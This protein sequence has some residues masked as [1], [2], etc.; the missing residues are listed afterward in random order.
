[1]LTH[2]EQGDCNELRTTIVKG[3]IVDTKMGGIQVKFTGKERLT[4]T[5][6]QDKRYEIS[7]SFGLVASRVSGRLRKMS[8]KYH[9]RVIIRHLLTLQL[10]AIWLLSIRRVQ[11]LLKLQT[12]RG[13]SESISK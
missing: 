5:G 12:C 9:T 3:E 4:Q 2:Q 6:L 11:R 7:F 10:V 1:M 8:A 13:K